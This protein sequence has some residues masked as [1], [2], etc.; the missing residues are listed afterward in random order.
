MLFKKNRKKVELSEKEF[1]LIYD[2]FYER[3]YRDAYFVIKDRYLAQDIVQDTFVK[4]YKHISNLESREKLG[5][6]LSTIATRTAIDLI[7]KQN[8]WNGIPTEDLALN[9]MHSKQEIASSVEVIVENEL[10]QE[11]LIV[12]ISE[13]KPEYREVIVLKYIHELKDT[14]IAQWTDLKE[15]TVKSRIHRAKKELRVLIQKDESC[16]PLFGGEIS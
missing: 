1:R 14:E 6:W 7:R 12:K 8:T 11:A 15:G 13:L 4:A 9:Y 10:I 16:K 5:A 3:V 2:L